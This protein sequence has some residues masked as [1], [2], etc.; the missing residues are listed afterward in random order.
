MRDN[1]TFEQLKTDRDVVWI[2][3]VDEQLL[4]SDFLKLV[5]DYQRRHAVRGRS[6]GRLTFGLP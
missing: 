6:A 2:T 4:W 3:D 1:M 5:D